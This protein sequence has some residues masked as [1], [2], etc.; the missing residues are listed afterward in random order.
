MYIDKQA[1][2]SWKGAMKIR[3]APLNFP[4]GPYCVKGKGRSNSEAW[5]SLLGATFVRH[6]MVGIAGIVRLFYS[7]RFVEMTLKWP[8]FNVDYDAGRPTK[9]SHACYRICKSYLPET[10]RHFESEPGTRILEIG[11]KIQIFSR[12]NPWPPTTKLLCDH[13]ISL[14]Y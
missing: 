13:P 4:K 10:H 7:I 8:A 2:H 11:T 9:P 6:S 5:R 1:V 3:I 12:E 14:F